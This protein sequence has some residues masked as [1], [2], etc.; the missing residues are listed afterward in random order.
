[1]ETIKFGAILEQMASP[2]NPTVGTSQSIDSIINNSFD[3]ATL[4]L[5]FYADRYDKATG[6]QLFKSFWH[7]FCM[8]YYTRQIGAETIGQFE[9]F[10]RSRFS[11]I[12]PWYKVLYDKVVSPLEGNTLDLFSTADY[13]TTTTEQSTGE[14]SSGTEYGHTVSKDN[15][16]TD[17]RTDATQRGGQDKLTHD[18]TI[19][20]DG[21][22]NDTRTDATS[23]SETHGG[24]DTVTEKRKLTGDNGDPRKNTSEQTT[25]TTNKGQTQA[26]ASNLYSDTPQNGLVDVANAR[27]L[28]NAVNQDTGETRDDTAKETVTGSTTIANENE[29]RTQ[30]TEHG[31]D[32]TIRNSGDI[33][34]E[35]SFDKTT[36]TTGSDTTEYGSDDTTK[37]TGTTKDAGTETHGGR[38]STTGTETRSRTIAVSVKGKQGGMSYAELLKDIMT[39]I[40]NIDEMIIND[41]YDLFLT[42]FD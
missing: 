15:T 37:H 5:P 42:V 35:A 31:A 24:T 4:N 29:E 14:T 16:R 32:V 20:E 18:V 3:R 34:T 23:R 1:M 21:T 38:D 36:R 26:T 25:D 28:T 11:E 2:T 9:L 41:C 17:D 6:E 13:T 7:K 8:H 12:M 10:L 33:K 30:T 27:Y 39:S 19:A 22:N 40:Y